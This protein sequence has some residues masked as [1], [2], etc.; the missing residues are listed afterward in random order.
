MKYLLDTNI[1]IY[2]I[3]KEPK[4]VLEYFTNKKPGDILI[5]AIT[6]AELYYGV[7]K[8]TKHNQ[9]LVAMEEFLQPFVIAEF[10]Q[11]ASAAYGVLR[12]QLERKGS[13]I[14]SM[15]MLIAATAISDNCI[16]VTNNEKEFKRIENLTIENWTK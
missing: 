12:A 6:V 16:L 11:A 15:D 5:S 3:K 1:C 7:T 10:N 4:K 8:S 13:V 2:I 9:N 14:G